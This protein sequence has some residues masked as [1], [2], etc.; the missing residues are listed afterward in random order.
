[1]RGKLRAPPGDL[2]RETHHAR[3][4]SS[5]NGKDTGARSFVSSP[6]ET[7]SAVT[8]SE[9]EGARGGYVEETESFGISGA[10]LGEGVSVCFTI[11]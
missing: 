9:L 7:G 11:V 1:M 6:S 4:P 2:Q 5:I 8:T 3:L 10:D